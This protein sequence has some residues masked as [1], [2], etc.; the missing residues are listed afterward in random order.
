MK[1]CII[2]LYPSSDKLLVKSLGC[3]QY[4]SEGKEYID[5]ESG[6]WC[7]NLGHSNENIINVIEKQ[8]RQSIHHGYRFRNQLSEEL[9]IKLQGLIG[10][11]NGSSVFL[12]SGS[13]A[14]NL[15]VS[16]AQKLTGR[17][18]ILKISNSYLSAYG[19]GQIKPDNEYLENITFN[20]LEAL[21]N[22]DFSNI[23]AFV[24]ETGGASVEMVR[25]PD[26]E[27]INELVLLAKSQKCLIIAEEVNTGMGRLGKWFGFQHYDIKPDIVVTGKALGNGYPISAI[28][29]NSAVS[30]R[31]CN[32]SFVYA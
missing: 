11:E 30:E 5:F 6:V 32:D 26:Y 21:N 17:K 19:F 3:Y 23:S 14:V 31:F 22:I 8:S 20:D 10:F 29:I 13:E 4:D 24:M 1:N 2:P 28:T 15:S 16:I 12:S 25:F 27:F 7:A 9:S 18:K